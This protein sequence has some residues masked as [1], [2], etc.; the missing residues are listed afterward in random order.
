MCDLASEKQRIDTILHWAMNRG[1]A[2]LSTDEAELASLGLAALRSVYTD[3]C[4]DECMRKRCEEY[5]LSV[6]QSRRARCA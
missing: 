5:A 4:P 6:V 3:T 2:R 1:G